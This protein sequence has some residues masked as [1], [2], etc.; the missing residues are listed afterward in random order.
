MKICHSEKKPH[1]SEYVSSVCGVR[2]SCPIR[3]QHGTGVVLRQNSV[4]SLKE[5]V[6]LPLYI[7]P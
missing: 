7:N 5:K 3:T 6:P 2:V 1:M 4:A